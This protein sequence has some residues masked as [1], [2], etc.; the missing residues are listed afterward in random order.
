M[1]TLSFFMLNMN[2]GKF[3]VLHCLQ[4]IILIVRVVRRIAQRGVES[5]CQD[6]CGGHA[7]GMKK[8]KKEPIPC[9]VSPFLR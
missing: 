1:E 4:S 2:S 7:I 9:G 8:I 6:R 3:I 5:V